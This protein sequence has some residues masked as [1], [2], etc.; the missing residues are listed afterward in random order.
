MTSKTNWKRLA[1]FA[2]IGLLI[3]GGVAAFF[4]FFR[5]GPAHTLNAAADSYRRGAQAL[6]SGDA[7]EAARLLDEAVLQTSQAIDR[8]EKERL[9]TKGDSPEEHAKRENMVG[10]AYWIKA[11]ALRDKAFAERKAEG[12]PLNETTD[13]TAGTKFRAIVVMPDRETREEALRSLRVAA[14][15]LPAELDVQRE[16]LR[17]E[18][19][20]NPTAWSLVE[21]ICENIVA[22]EPLDT[23]ANY[24]LANFN[25]E[26]PQIDAKGRQLEPLPLAKR[27]A[28]RMLKA[29]TYIEATKKSPDHKF[30][31]TRDLETKVAL[32]L[33]EDYTRQGKAE[34]AA[35]E[36]KRIDAL[37]LDERDGVLARASADTKLPEASVF[38]LK[39][40]LHLYQLALRETIRE[41]R[42]DKEAGKRIAAVVDAALDLAA[43]ATASKE[44]GN[45]ATS[46]K[47]ALSVLAEARPY[48]KDAAPRTDAVRKMARAA[49][50]AKEA[51]LELYTQM[52]RLLQ[53]DSRYAAKAGD[54]PAREALEKEIDTWL[55]DGLAKV[56]ERKTMDAASFELTLLAA[57]RKTLKGV[58]AS[59]EL[60]ILRKTKLPQAIA[61]A[62]FLEG[63]S[64]ERAGRLDRA[65]KLFEESDPEGQ[66]LRVNLALSQV[67]LALAQPDRALQRLQRVAAAYADIEESPDREWIAEFLPSKEEMSYLMI[68]SRLGAARQ[69]MAEFA[70]TNPGRPIPAE[71][72][73][74]P[75]KDVRAA[76]D[77]MPVESRFRDRARQALIN[78]FVMLRRPKEARAELALAQKEQTANVELLQSEVAVLALEA[79]GNNAEARK[80]VDS[81]LQSYLS[82]NPADLS[83]KLLWAMWLLRTDR[84]EEATKYLQ[85]PAF[86][87]DK[88][89][90]HQRMLALALLESGQREAGMKLLQHLPSSPEVDAILVR[91]T[92]DEKERAELLSKASARH[93]RNG[94]LRMLNASDL[95]SKKQWEKA[96]KEYFEGL[97]FAQVRSS[98]ERGLLQALFAWSEES[99]A[100]ARKKIEAMLSETP[101][102]KTL[103]LAYAYACLKVDDLGTPGDNW[104]RTRNMATALNVW[105]QLQRKSG[106]DANTIALT[107]AEFW[108]RA[109]RPA[110]AQAEMRKADDSKNVAVVEVLTRLALSETNPTLRADAR[111]HLEVL[112]TLKPNAPEVDIYEAQLL[113]QEKKAKESL[114]L[115]EKA[116]EKH[117]KTRAIPFLLTN[118]LIRQ[119]QLDKATTVLAEWR[120]RFPEDAEALLT[121]VTLESMRKNVDAARRTADEYLNDQKAR[122]EKL[123]KEKKID[124]ARDKILAEVETNA[125]WQL[126]RAFLRAKNVEDAETRLGEVLK[127]NPEH[128]PS[129]MLKGEIDMARKDWAGAAKSYEVLLKKNPQHFVAANNLA[130]LLTEHL[131]APDRA[132]KLVDSFRR[133]KYSDQPLSGDRLRLEFLD[134]IGLAYM[135]SKSDVH[136]EMK[137]L[138]EEARRRYPHDPRLCVYLAHAQAK[139][140]NEKLAQ[141]L[142]TAAINL[143]QGE[144]HGLSTAERDSVLQMAQAARKQ[145]DAGPR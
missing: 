8:L 33:R 61:Q 70:R 125:G 65:R 7:S 1:I 9:T 56:K 119:D 136:A 83:G 143:A 86:A 141:D 104:D 89:Q 128:E 144:D 93:E 41:T 115:L 69:R 108:L 4:I 11:I 2:C 25:Y 17:T 54:E 57:E 34:K 130:Y 60:E 6:E 92:K 121:A 79:G 27:S 62:A 101:T 64:H 32:W 131:G 90:R 47:G 14:M 3:G 21:K 52:T 5:S 30:W 66:S 43:K 75:E 134:T 127:K 71:L 26:Q 96:A 87:A 31:R 15:R 135:K 39:A 67:Y 142:L 58:S 13:T 129:L 28:S 117:P 50:E 94:M 55:N 74:T 40:A 145:L 137:Q 103:Y 42:G 123:F 24:Q 76:L 106:G 138:F 48:L 51:D 81:R 68:V 111:K 124:E 29:R 109:G 78:H 18:V 132:L 45:T 12:K 100:D 91:L 99:P 114:A 23:R 16:A 73:E 110:Q 84:A 120:K 22:K 113:A 112:K 36:E 44:R 98:A 102:E 80:K 107:R 118:E 97:E 10:Q 133:S 95:L 139:L 38:D 19:M 77:K 122:L 59:E 85:G 88:D 140:G 72:F 46:A 116:L 49:V 37:L 35:E 53:L 126:A 63:V 105:E 82:E 20:L